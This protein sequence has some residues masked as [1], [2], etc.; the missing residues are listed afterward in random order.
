MKQVVLAI[1][2]IWS[3][4]L[5]RAEWMYF[6]TD[7]DRADYINKDL[8][9]NGDSVRFWVIQD[10]KKAETLE[11]KNI[12]YVSQKNL[13]QI[14]CADNQFKIIVLEYY[15]KHM[16]GG[17]KLFAVAEPGQSMDITPDTF[18]EALKEFV[19]K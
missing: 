15:D 1:T 14:D 12:S 9:F 17:A 3:C 7:G 10:Y 6:G 13:Y 11:D 18:G 16:G 5:L 8:Q 4:S 19:C 2:L